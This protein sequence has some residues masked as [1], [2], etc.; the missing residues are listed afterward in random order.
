MREEITNGTS[1][2]AI[3]A[4]DSLTLQKPAAFARNN[5]VPS[6]GRDPEFI[7]TAFSLTTGS[8]S[9]PVEGFRGYYLI[10]LLEKT[11][12]QEQDYLAQKAE[13]RAEIKTQKEQ[14]AFSQWYAQLRENAEI[15]DY[16]KQYF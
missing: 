3:A 5:S 10:R 7:G 11:P 6:V 13:L 4:R 9:K 14:A 12:I 16:R 8:L 15:K 1:I 2:E